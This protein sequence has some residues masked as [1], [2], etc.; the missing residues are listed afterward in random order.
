M[1]KESITSDID[2]DFH[3]ALSAL[4]VGNLTDAMKWSEAVLRLE[5][6]HFGALNVMAVVST[7]SRAGATRAIT[8]SSFT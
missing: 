3:S 6:K 5:R 7:F 8:Q 4:Q 1:S 2:R